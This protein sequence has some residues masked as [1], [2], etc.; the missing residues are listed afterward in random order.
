MRDTTS[1]KFRS[2]RSL[3]MQQSSSEVSTRPNRKWKLGRERRLTK[4]RRIQ[5]R[6]VWVGTWR[7]LGSR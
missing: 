3:P 7:S 6:N 4:L 1:S 2:P 5:T